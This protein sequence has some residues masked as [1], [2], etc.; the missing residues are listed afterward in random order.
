MR[1]AVIACGNGL[2][3]VKRACKIMAALR[4]MCPTWKQVL[5]C[6][7]WQHDALAD[8]PYFESLTKTAVVMPVRWTTN[9][10]SAWLDWDGI[11][12]TWKLH[13]FDAVLSD[14]LVEPLVVGR[15]T[16]LSGSFLWHDIL[17]NAFPDDP[18]TQNYA[19]RCEA[20]L[21]KTRP[22]MLV[23]RY[24]AMPSTYTYVTPHPIGMVSCYEGPMYPRT[25]NVPREVL[26]ALGN[27]P[28]VDEIFSQFEAILPSLA[29]VRLWLPQ[30]WYE[31]LS[32]R[33][34]PHIELALY[35]FANNPLYTIDVAIIRAGMGT[36]SD[37][38]A[39]HIPMF[40]LHDSN[41]EIAWNEQ[42]LTALGIGQPFSLKLK[43]AANYANMRACFAPLSYNGAYEAAQF[44]IQYLQE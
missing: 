27:N 31:I 19:A 36:I 4:E 21:I 43:S 29:G 15:R 30:R 39:A 40:Y 5:F 8:W 16:I 35:D 32:Q 20:V 24:F 23:N 18:V 10:D 22:P 9:L 33:K 13:T 12:S 7:P 34:L 1:L 2:G 6:E 44:I 25:T 42:R 3:H 28:R 26:V 14:N 11:I 17:L 38:V 37:C 41:P